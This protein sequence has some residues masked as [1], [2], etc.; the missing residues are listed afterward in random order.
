MSLRRCWWLSAFFEVAEV[1]N[2]LL[3]LG[4]PLEVADVALIR[5]QPSIN[6][7]D[8]SKP[9]IETAV[10]A[11]IAGAAAIFQLTIQVAVLLM[12]LSIG[13]SPHSLSFP[14]IGAA[15][16]SPMALS[17]SARLLMAFSFP[18]RLPTPLSC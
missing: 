1:S 7:N 4:F 3:A 13:S 10:V 18:S 2:L 6:A 16:V 9:L 8:V 12:A 14:S 5:S 15:V 11:P 17:F